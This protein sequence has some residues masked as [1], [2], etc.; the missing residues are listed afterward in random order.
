[1]ATEVRAQIDEEGVRR[2]VIPSEA[3]RI[4]DETNRRAEELAARPSNRRSTWRQIDKR[5]A[6]S[7]RDRMRLVFMEKLAKEQPEKEKSEKDKLDFG[8]NQFQS[9]GND[10]WD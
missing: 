6:Q 3:K 10:A 1:M 9:T 5:A 4:R 2:R 7:E 8:K